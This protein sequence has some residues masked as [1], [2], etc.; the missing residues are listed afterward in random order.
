MTCS[1]EMAMQRDDQMWTA[2]GDKVEPDWAPER[3][4]AVRA[5]I[6][7]RATRRRAALRTAVAVGG[8][9][10]VSWR[11]PVPVG[12]P[13]VSGAISDLRTPASGGEIGI[14]TV[15]V[16]QLSPET[17]LAPLADRNGRGFALRA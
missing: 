15:T 5:A 4:W 2:L 1:L 11:S 9:A 10:L 16:T 8:F 13:L 7:R 3:E 14:E 17:V 12:A 6:A